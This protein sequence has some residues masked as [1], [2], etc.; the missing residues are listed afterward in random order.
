MTGLR[1]FYK[2]LLLNLQVHVDQKGLPV[3]VCPFDK[4]F[5]IVDLVLDKN[6][7]TIAF[8]LFLT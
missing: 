6:F 5:M 7:T 8:K 2:N 3:F 1:V 4:Y